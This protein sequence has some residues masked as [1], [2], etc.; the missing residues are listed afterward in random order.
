MKYLC[1]VELLHL[2]ADSQR[3]ALKVTSTGLSIPA[4]R[5]RLS[6]TCAP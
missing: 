3:Q 1:H 2:N 4:V 6:Q 5:L